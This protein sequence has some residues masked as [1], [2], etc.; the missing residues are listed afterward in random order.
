MTLKLPVNF[1]LMLD[2]VVLRRLKLPLKETPKMVRW[3]DFVGRLKNPIDTVSIALVGKY[4][5]LKDA[6]KSIAEAFVHG[7]AENELRVKVNWV[8]SEDLNDANV[9]RLLKGHDGILVAPG[10]GERGID[11]KLLAVKYARENGIPFLGIC[12]GMQVAV[13]EFGRNVLG[14][15]NCH[16]TEFLPEATN[17]VICLMEGQKSVQQLGGTD[18]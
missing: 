2:Q 14:L 13:V 18:E 16:S 5:E 8:H 15:S 10:F 6:Y 17:P 7:G 4:V 12:L 11:G 9:E 3:R 1:F